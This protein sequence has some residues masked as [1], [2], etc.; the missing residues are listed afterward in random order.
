MLEGR[1]SDIDLSPTV[2]AN[3]AQELVLCIILFSVRI[4]FAD[5]SIDPISAIIYLAHLNV[6]VCFHLD[7]SLHV[8]EVFEVTVY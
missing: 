3:N 7:Q 6:V 2:F 1:I 4:S 8:S 5:P